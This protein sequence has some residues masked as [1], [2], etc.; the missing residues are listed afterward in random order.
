M[1]I[2]KIKNFPFANK[3]IPFIGGLLYASAFPIKGLPSFPLGSILGLAMLF[4]YFSLNYNETKKISLKN[5]I[6]SFLLFSL[7]YNLFGYYWIPELLKVFGGLFFPVNYILG[8]LFTLII[9]P[10]IF[11][12]IVIK[13]FARKKLF[14]TSFTMVLLTALFVLLE[15]FVPQQFPAH[16]GHPFLWFAPYIG[17]SKFLGAPYYSFI[18]VFLALTIVRS[19]KTKKAD[20][21][22]I[23]V[24]IALIL[25]GVVVPLQKSEGQN[26][27]NL[28]LVQGNIGNDLKIHSENGLQLALGEVITIYRNL[29]ISEAQVTPDLIV[30]PETSFPRILDSRLMKND[31]ALTPY[32]FQMIAQKMGSEIF[33]GGYDTSGKRN[34]FFFETQ[35]NAAFHFSENARLKDAYHKRILIPFGESLPFGPLN[36]FLAKYIE[37]ISFFAAGTTYPLFETKKNATFSAAICYEILFSS[38]I[39]DY[40]N[41]TKKIPDFIINITNDSWYGNTSEPLQHL[42]L[43]HWR[44]IEFNVP[45]VR[46]TNTGITSILYE[47]GSESERLAYHTDGVLDLPIVVDKNLAPTV[48]QQYGIWGNGILWLVLSLLFFARDRKSFFH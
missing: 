23:G 18:S 27:L 22:S 9:T 47:D 34:N 37:N 6:V 24:S 32:T 35:H 8:A 46:V 4:Y 1:T 26:E 48:F 12:F 15:Y 36:E 10:H 16:A 33:I 43:S 30:W 45:I 11:A 38:F 19:L 21:L 7:G 13:Y 25:A 29:S 3:S 41:N 31:P 17:I 14:N 2:L 5:E 42:F 39:R 40:L 28:R 20:V 44:A